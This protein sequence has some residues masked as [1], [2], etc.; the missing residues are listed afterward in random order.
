[1]TN[2]VAPLTIEYS[3]EPEAG[4]GAVATS[5]GNL[6]LDAVDIRAAIA[7]TSASVELTQGFRNPFDVPEE[8]T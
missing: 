2:D 7:G 3:A 8:A 4:L 1:M 6:P 5:R